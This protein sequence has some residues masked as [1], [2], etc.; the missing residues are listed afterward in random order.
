MSD[1]TRVSDDLALSELQTAFANLEAKQ[2]E[3][4]IGL[5]SL[6]DRPKLPYLRP[7]PFFAAKSA[8]EP[9][10]QAIL[11]MVKNVSEAMMSSLPSFWRISK[12][13]MEGKFKKVRYDICGFSLYSTK[14]STAFDLIVRRPTKRFSMS[15]YGLRRCEALYIP[16]FRVLHPIRHDCYGFPKVQSPT[17]SSCQVAFNV[18]CLLPFENA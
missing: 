1:S 17:P 7:F 3:V 6:L 5:Q 8:D 13:F 15:N 4:I 16:N 9:L 12:D 11:D 14:L 10:W 18:D 2:A